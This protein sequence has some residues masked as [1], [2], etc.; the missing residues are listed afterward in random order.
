LESAQ[1]CSF[2]NPTNNATTNDSQHS[3]NNAEVYTRLSLANVHK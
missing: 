3:H 1:E 2:P